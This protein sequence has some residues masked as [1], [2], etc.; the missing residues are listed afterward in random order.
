MFTVRMEARVTIK[1]CLLVMC[2]LTSVCAVGQSCQSGDCQAGV[3]AGPFTAAQ[4]AENTAANFPICNGTS[5]TV[6]NWSGS[7]IEG[8]DA[9]Q[10][11]GTKYQFF[12][13]ALNLDDNIA[14]GPTI[15]GQNAQVLEWVNTHNI[16]AFD[17]ATGKALYS[18]AGGTTGNPRNVTNLWSSSTQAEC[19]GNSGNV[20]VI[21]DR[22]DNAFVI[23][24]RVTYT[25]AGI[26]HYAWCVALSSGSD[27]SNKKTAW[28]AYEYRMDT[29]I[30]CLPSS[31]QC[32]TGSAYYYYPDW[33]RI[34][35]WS[36]AFCVTFDLQ[37]VTY[38]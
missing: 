18:F 14:V 26:P 3:I 16:Q 28:Y 19:R 10:N 7:Q 35:T 12:D 38:H 6:Q 2:V 27:L 34:G 13:A 36:N 22:L 20:Q 21:Y 1:N 23:N 37:D 17:K 31:N 32:S 24:R 29:V 15:S 33:P 9:Q 30:P 5:C 25:V 8:I 11:M 4:T